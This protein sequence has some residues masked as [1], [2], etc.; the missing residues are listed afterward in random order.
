MS[1]AHNLRNGGFHNPFQRAKAQQVQELLNR[2]QKLLIREALIEAFLEHRA[3]L[4]S[5][6]SANDSIQSFSREAT[7][8][9]A[10][11]ERLGQK[12][13]SVERSIQLARLDS[14]SDRHEYEKKVLAAVASSTAKTGQAMTEGLEVSQDRLFGLLTPVLDPI[15]G[16]LEALIEHS[17]AMERRSEELHSQVDASLRDLRLEH[18]R[19]A[20]QAVTEALDGRRAE[21][22]RQS[23]THQPRAVTSREATISV[24]ESVDSSGHNCYS[25]ERSARALRQQRRNM[26]K[27][28]VGK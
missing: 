11:L 15:V 25:S 8:I 13:D 24:A 9:N 18:T 4:G 28:R 12:V 21:L 19:L 6:L 3:V 1:Q 22:L 2:R 17:E 5:F 23:R 20:A 7:K 16:N 10:S 27:Q 14:S 26:L